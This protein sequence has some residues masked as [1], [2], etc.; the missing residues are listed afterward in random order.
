MSL[1]TGEE[2]AADAC[3][4]CCRAAI[5]AV[6]FRN[7][8][9]AVLTPGKQRQVKGTRWGWGEDGPPQLVLMHGRRPGNEKAPDD[10]G[11]SG[12]QVG[13]GQRS[14]TRL[15]PVLRGM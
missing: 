9:L 4:G 7:P 2:Y 12:L 14:N 3:N 8:V 5:A 6:V 10:A 15:P 11:A 13:L 1:S